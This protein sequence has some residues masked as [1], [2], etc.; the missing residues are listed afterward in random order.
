MHQASRVLIRHSIE[1]CP[2][3]YDTYNIFFNLLLDSK[4]QAFDLIQ[5][6]RKV[7]EIGNGLTNIAKNNLVCKTFGIRYVAS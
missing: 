2:H 3:K 7:K 5:F 1:I 6:I 4:T